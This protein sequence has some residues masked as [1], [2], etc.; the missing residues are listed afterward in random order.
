M[1]MILLEWEK[2]TTNNEPYW[3]FWY[4]DPINN[5]VVEKITKKVITEIKE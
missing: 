1:E 2:D 3:R 4:Y 5:V